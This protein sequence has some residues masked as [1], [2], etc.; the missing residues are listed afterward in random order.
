MIRKAVTQYLDHDPEFKWRGDDV[1]RLENL[2]DI[3][4][5]LAFG[6]IVSASNAPQTLEGLN[7]FLIGAPPVILAFIIMTQFWNQHF[8]YFRRYALADKRIF[9]LNSL[10]LLSILFIAYTLRFILESLY[11]YAIGVGLGNLDRMEALG[12]K[13]FRDAAQITGYFAI[14]FGFVQALFSMMVAHAYRAR[15]ALKLSALEVALTKKEIW[16]ARSEI[17]IA[18]AAAAIALATPIGPFSGFLL[19]LALPLELVTTR[20]AKRGL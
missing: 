3:V 19:L 9:F 1:T 11:A 7:E 20:M 10:L 4:F 13:S 15:D 16:Q 8:I 14:G 18:A 2:S 6:M 5:A 17:G 12:I